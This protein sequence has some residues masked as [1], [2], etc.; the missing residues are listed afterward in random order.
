MAKF[1]HSNT[2]TSW[3]WALFGS[4]FLIIFRISSLVK[5][6]VDSDSWVFIVKVAGRT[7]Q[8]FIRDRYLFFCKKVL[9]ISAFLWKSMINLFS[10]NN[11]EIQEIFL[12][13]RNV[14]NI[15]QYDFKSYFMMAVFACSEECTPDSITKFSCELNIKSMQENVF[16]VRWVGPFMSWGNPNWKAMSSVWEPL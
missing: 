16:L 3:P 11:G 8:V 1:Y 9:N 10:C 15:Y 2:Y 4:N 13:F 14:F 12:L 6:I 7:L 5:W